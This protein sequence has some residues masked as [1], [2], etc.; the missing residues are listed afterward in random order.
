MKIIKIDVFLILA[1]VL[2]ISYSYETNDFWGMLNYQAPLIA[3]ILGSLAMTYLTALE[4]Y[5]S[6]RN[7]EHKNKNIKFTLEKLAKE[8][9]ELKERNSELEERN[10]EYRNEIYK[11]KD[12]IEMKK[13]VKDLR[14]KENELIIRAEKA[15]YWR[16]NLFH[17]LQIKDEEMQEFKEIVK[18]LENLSSCFIKSKESYLEKVYIK[19]ALIIEDREKLRQELVNQTANNIIL[20]DE[21]NKLKELTIKN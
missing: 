8:N 14:K 18:R 19:I 1:L 2:I 5:K 13:W 9:D 6:M 4:N 17:E 16:K 20:K 11:F 10:S 12:K 21:L 7:E 15:E 3:C